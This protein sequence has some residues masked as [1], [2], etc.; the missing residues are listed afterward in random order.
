MT[1]AGGGGTG[2][3][4]WSRTRPDKMM[5][6]LHRPRSSTVMPAVVALLAL[7]AGLLI[8]LAERDPAHVWLMPAGWSIAS[9]HGLLP[10]VVSNSG[11]SFL[12]AYSFSVLTGLCLQPR[13]STRAIACASW[14]AI[15]TLFEIGQH[16]AVGRAIS[17]GWSRWFEWTAGPA[18]LPLFFPQGTFDAGD[19]LAAS[20]GAAAA[21]ATLAAGRLPRQE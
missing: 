13:R 11:P 12:H 2:R 17:A 18:S 7:G 8:Y 14:F 9:L 3:D 16:P 20:V 21:F 15:D 19:C 6:A 5:T 10:A 1:G 4:V